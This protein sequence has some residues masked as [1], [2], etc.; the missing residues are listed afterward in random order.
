M[1]C[2]DFN[3]WDHGQ[4]KS[5]VQ[6]DLRAQWTPTIPEFVM[7]ICGA[8]FWNLLGTLEISGG[9]SHGPTTKMIDW[10]PWVTELQSVI[11]LEFELW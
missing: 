5:N 4:L 11:S 2:Q 9:K 6:F 3:I 8:T 7:Y 1:C 10:G